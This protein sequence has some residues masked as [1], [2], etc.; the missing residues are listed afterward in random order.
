VFK[1][2]QNISNSAPTSPES[3]LR[4]Q[5]A[6]SGRYW[7]QTATRPF[8]IWALV[9]ELHPLNWAVHRNADKV[10]MQEREE[11]RVCVRVRVCVKFCCK[12]GKKNF[13]DT[14]Q[15]L[16]Q[17]YG[18]YCVKGLL[19]H[20][21]SRDESVKYR[22]MLVLVFWLERHCPSRIIKKI[23]EHHTRKPRR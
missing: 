5:R 14:F 16:N 21:K 23:R 6:P 10:T 11:Q 7:Q 15:L 2:T 13:T 4:L 18:E 20:N 12:L 19:N 17:S 22:V 8:S 1:N 3:T 9:V